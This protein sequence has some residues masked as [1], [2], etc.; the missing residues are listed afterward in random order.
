MTDKARH[1]LQFLSMVLCAMLAGCGEEDQFPPR[2]NADEVAIFFERYNEKNATDTQNAIKETEA[3]LA[4]GDLSEIDRKEKEA[5]LEKLRYRAKYPEMFTFATLNDLPDD[6]QWESNWVAPEIGSDKAKKGGVFNYYF[7]GLTYPQ[8]LRVVGPKSNNYFRGDHYD[9]IEMSC[10]NIHPD[11]S[12]IIPS[13]AKE[14]AISPDKQTVYFR[15]DENA[16]Y[17]DCLLYTSPSP[18]DQRGS[19]MPSSA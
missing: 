13:L 14:W 18:R 4:K 2:D 12:E 5:Q 1:T 7:E 15:L 19:R 8:T 6:L 10:V 3:E 16:K 9:Y 11:T 17:N